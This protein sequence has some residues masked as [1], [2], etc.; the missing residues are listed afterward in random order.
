MTIDY[1]SFSDTGQADKVQPV[2]RWWTQSETEMPKSLVAIVNTLSQ[3]DSRRV[4]QC[5]TSA[6]LYGNISLTGLSGLTFAKNAASGGV[7]KDRISYNVVQAGVDTVVAKMIKNKPKPLALT[8]RGNWHQ[9]R[10]AEKINTFVDGIF[11]EQHAYDHGRESLRDAAVLGDGLT[12]VLEE[13]SRVKFERVLATELLVDEMEAF[14][15]RPRQLHRVRNM[16]RAVA[17]DLFPEKADLIKG[18]N[19]AKSD[20][21]GVNQTI[22]DQI[23]VVESWHLPSSPDAN[24]GLHVICIEDGILFKEEWDRPYFPFARLP[25]TPRLYGYWSQSGAEQIQNIQLE[26]NKLLWV[27]QRSM[28]MAG[29]FKILAERGARIV[30]EHFTNDFG[31]VLEYTGTPPSYVIPPIVPPEIYQHLSTLKAQAFEQLGVSMLSATAQKPAGLNAGKALRE[32]QDI[33]SER[34]EALGQQYERYYLDLAMLSIDFVKRIFERE[35][36]Y[37]VKM[38]GKAFLETID[39]KDIKM[40]D[41]EYVLKMFPVSSL[42]QDPAGRLQTIQE[43]IQAGFISPRSGRRLLDYPDI[44]QAETMANA[45]EDWLH[46]VIEQMLD[47]GEPYAPEPDDDLQLA[48]ELAIQYI[49][50]AKVSKAEP[51][52]I[53]LVRQFLAKVNEMLAGPLQQAPELPPATPQANAMPPPTSDLIPNAPGVAA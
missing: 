40:E 53:E 1:K 6:K 11:Y 25:W 16:D 47:D 37:Q 38:P 10:K 27:I 33:E 15:G 45:A 24:D 8:G 42:P 52:R 41:D 17:V 39:W 34:F 48:Q 43:Y 29:T 20:L 36:K 49:N 18:T 30:K 28:H 23:T 44:E 26:I 19:A 7:I 9:Q 51:D 4:S 32:Y 50:F 2:S 22:S 5:Q 31:V 35:G 13:H 14:Y 3:A 46:E 21:T 12:Q